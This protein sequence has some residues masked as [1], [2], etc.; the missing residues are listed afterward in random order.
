MQ[1][2]VTGACGRL[3]V[4]AVRR[5][6]A[7][8]HQAI[9]F[10]LPTPA[11]R[12]IARTLGPQVRTCYGD[13]RNPRDVANAVEGVDAVIHN[14]GIL[15][16][17][18]EVAPDAARSVNVDGTMHLLRA[19][20]A[21]SQRPRLVYAST[22]SVCG[23]R[24]PGGLPLTSDHP[25]TGTDHYTSHKA[26]CEAMIR[27]SMVPWVIFR[28]GVS[29]S[30]QAKDFSPDV[31]RL[32]FSIDP[33]TR[34]EYVHP[35]DVALAQVR[36]LA[37]PGAL[38][39]VLMIGGG[40]AC[41]LTFKEFYDAIFEAS[42]VGALPAKA[43]SDAPY[44]CDWLDTTESQTLLAYQEHTF[45]DFIREFRHASRRTRP[46]VRALSPL[47]RWYLLRYSDAWNGRTG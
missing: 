17:R 44:Y 12:R 30:A 34:L 35:R 4:E 14:A 21:S 42:G 45:D 26:E 40:A 7:E 13:M 43:Y 32:L 25:A 11:N 9:A 46:V 22:L 37:V 16:P 47:I 15:A 19:M 24:R 5:L 10:D 39:K 1:V 38:H 18:T 23:P 27:T 41:R 28:I 8:G 33:T 3:G 20:E 29:V 2:L 6:A 36:A 31:L